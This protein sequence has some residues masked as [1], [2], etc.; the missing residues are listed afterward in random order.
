MAEHRGHTEPGQRT[1]NRFD[2][3]MSPR[4]GHVEQRLEG[5]ER[6]AFQCRTNHADLLIGERRKVGDGAFLDLAVFAVGLPQQVSGSGSS[7]GYDVYMHAPIL[8]Q[9]QPMSTYLHGYT[10]HTSEAFVTQ[11]PYKIGRL[12]SEGGKIRRELQTNP[13][14]IAMPVA[15]PKYV[16]PAR[17]PDQG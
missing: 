2:V 6:F 10:S 9:N 12:R 5:V 11:K 1:P 16:G 14:V 15:M 13:S 8:N 3:A 17:S 4:L 7:I